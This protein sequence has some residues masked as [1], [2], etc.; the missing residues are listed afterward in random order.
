MSGTPQVEGFPSTLVHGEAR[1]ATVVDVQRE[2][3]ELHFAAVNAVQ[4][5]TQRRI[6]W[7]LA[8]YGDRAT[9]AD[10]TNV[11]TTSDRTVRKH[12]TRL[13]DAGIVNRVNANKVFIEFASKDAKI[14][15]HEALGRW[16]DANDA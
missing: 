11:V 15:T 12:V 8:H 6:L 16:Y 3:P 9:Y 5:D 2:N 1:P 10:L 13:D 4:T 14:L 7:K